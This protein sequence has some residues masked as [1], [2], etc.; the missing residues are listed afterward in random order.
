MTEATAEDAALARLSYESY[1]RKREERER[2]KNSFSVRT[3]CKLAL[4]FCVLWF[5]ANYSY[6]EALL[7][8]EAAIVNILSSTSGLFTLIL[9]A[10]WSSG[11]GDKFTLSKLIAVLIRYFTPQYVYNSLLI[12]SSHNTNTEHANLICSQ[13]DMQPVGYPAKIR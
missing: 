5:V 10:V 6:Q 2:F 12:Q 11:P 8:T 7:G 3:V 4:L 1:L 9:A 13:S